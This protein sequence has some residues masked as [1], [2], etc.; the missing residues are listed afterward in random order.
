MNEPQV[1][2][3]ENTRRIAE[4]A[5]RVIK[6][7]SGLSALAIRYWKAGL[8]RRAKADWDE[9]D[10]GILAQ[11]AGLM[12]LLQIEREALLREGSTIL[13]PGNNLKASPRVSTVSTLVSS[14]ATLNRTI[15]LQHAK[16]P[17]HALPKQR[18][19]EIS[20]KIEEGIESSSTTTDRRMKLIKR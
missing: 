15:G 18:R 2:S 17:G 6:P 7:P 4:S 10:L 19:D 1:N 3:L 8:A 11:L 9:H 13:R 20:R 5:D 16:R 12:E 14:I